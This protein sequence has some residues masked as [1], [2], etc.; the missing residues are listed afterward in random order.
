[1]Y[2]LYDQDPAEKDKIDLRNG[3]SLLRQV[4][5]VTQGVV[6]LY[7]LL[8][9][10]LMTVRQGVSNPQIFTKAAKKVH[11]LPD[12]RRS[13]KESIED[14]RGFLECDKEFK[15]QDYSTDTYPLLLPGLQMMYPDEK[16]L[17]VSIVEQ[18]DGEP[19]GSH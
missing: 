10:G 2:Q 18:N 5:S 19:D 1:V 3:V 12:G 17:V 14:L 11:L 6:D 9:V 8:N 7:G 16:R 4:A 13:F 15:I